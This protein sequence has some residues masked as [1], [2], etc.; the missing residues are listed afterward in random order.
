MRKTKKGIKARHDMLIQLSWVDYDKEVNY[1][2]RSY[3]ALGPLRPS[4]HRTDGCSLNE[5]W[6]N[7]GFIHI[8]QWMASGLIYCILF[9]LDMKKELL[10]FF[11]LF[12]FSASSQC[13]II[14]FLQNTLTMKVWCF[15]F[16]WFPSKHI[17]KQGTKAKD[18]KKKKNHHF[19]CPICKV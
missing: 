2:M 1:R 18:K 3:F 14:L 6:S 13:F 11:C 10:I 5:Q 12:F 19:G 16:L 4:V 17:E 9:R 7:I 15:F 8:V